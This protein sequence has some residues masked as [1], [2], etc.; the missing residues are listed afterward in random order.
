MS[1]FNK[2]ICEAHQ[3]DGA[4]LE[5]HALVSVRNR[6]S[7]R[8]CFCCACLHVLN[9]RERARKCSPFGEPATVRLRADQ[10]R[11]DRLEGKWN[12]QN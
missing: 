12:K 10:R 7:C 9:F 11:Q 4:E 3:L 5:R 6:H 1:G 2:M 8:E